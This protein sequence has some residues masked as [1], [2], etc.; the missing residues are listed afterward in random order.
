MTIDESMLF[1][2]DEKDILTRIKP[3]QDVGLGY[4]KLEQE[5][6]IPS[7]EAKRS[8]SSSLLFW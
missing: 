5:S 2:I 8:V 1:F 6:S 7:V 3:L 4:V